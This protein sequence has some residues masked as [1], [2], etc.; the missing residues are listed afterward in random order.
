MSKL[1]QM[2]LSWAIAATMIIGYAAWEVISDVAA[3]AA[4]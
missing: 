3:R 4:K 1:T 2:Y